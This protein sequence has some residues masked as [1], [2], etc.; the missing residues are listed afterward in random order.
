MKNKGLFRWIYWIFIFSVAMGFA[1]AAV[2]VY[3]RMIYYPEGFAFPL[4]VLAE[5]EIIVEVYREIATLFILV[6]F[7]AL[8]GR[9]VRE[10]FSCFIASFGIWD[11]FYYLWLKILLDWPST[12]F[13]WDILFL[14]PIP[15]IGP[16]IAPIT[17]SLLMILC[18]IIIFTLHQHGRGMRFTGF[19]VVLAISG[20][21]VILYSF[22]HDTEATLH[23]QMP[24]PYRYEL[25]LL[26]GLL[27][28]AA[29]V[30]SYR[31]MNNRY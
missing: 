16:V 27:Y 19:S 21:I 29:F 23:Q 7:S 2:V 8:A 12:L 14:I 15:W 13:D 28:I 18:G 5:Q 11:I 30:A 22:M 20:S 4:K 24:L 9:T 26:G 1:E 25:L 31:E 3:L 10:R 6:A 17:V